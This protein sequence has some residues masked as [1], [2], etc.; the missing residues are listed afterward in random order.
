MQADR[1][2]MGERGRDLDGARRGTGSGFGGEIAK[3]ANS[4]Y[5][6]ASKPAL[7]IR[8]R[9]L[10]RSVSRQRTV[11]RGRNST[12]K[13]LQCSSQQTRCRTAGYGE[14]TR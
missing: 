6:I 9:T 4:Q 10:Y 3:F 14:I 11:G 2:L 8:N 7:Q 12:G 5:V 1:A 13:L